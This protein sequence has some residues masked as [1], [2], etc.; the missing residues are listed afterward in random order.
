MV[1]KKL[2]EFRRTA[3]ETESKQGAYSIEV[4]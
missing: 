2:V 1:T 4:R 3:D